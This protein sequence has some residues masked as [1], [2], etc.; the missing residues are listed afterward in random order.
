MAPSGSLAV[1]R[2]AWVRVQAPFVRTPWHAAMNMTLTHL[3]RPHSLWLCPVH[4]RGRSRYAQ[5]NQGARP[6]WL[7]GSVTEA[8]FPSCCCPRHRWLVVC[9]PYHV[10]KKCTG[11]TGGASL[12]ATGGAAAER[13]VHAAAAAQPARAARGFRAGRRAGGGAAAGASTAAAGAPGA[14]RDGAE[15]Q[16]RRQPVK[17]RACARAADVAPTRRAVCPLLRW[18]S[19]WPSA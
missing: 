2:S 3:P 12:A 15:Q 5:R 8:L 9:N 16:Q 1:R 19:H 10:E 11:L 17:P 18:V 14:R 4:V 13:T 6:C 7:P